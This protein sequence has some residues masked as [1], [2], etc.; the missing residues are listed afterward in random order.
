[1][2]F[3]RCSR[4]PKL[5]KE[6]KFVLDLGISFRRIVI[7]NCFS[8]FLSYENRELFENCPSKL[9]TFACEHDIVMHDIGVFVLFASIDVFIYLFINH[10][11]NFF[12]KFYP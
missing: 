12:D 1:M 8:F 10:T 11:I 6:G 7:I 4:D 5:P 9:R 3:A 2:A